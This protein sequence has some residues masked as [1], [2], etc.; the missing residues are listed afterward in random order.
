M[1][2]G[3]DPQGNYGWE[4]KYMYICVRTVVKEIGAKIIMQFS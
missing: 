4:T 1:E 3:A 2:E